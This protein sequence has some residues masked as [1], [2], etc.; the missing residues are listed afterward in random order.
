MS[1]K[2]LKFRRLNDAQLSEIDRLSDRF[3]ELQRDGQ[4]PA[5]S[6]FI[7][8]APPECRESL[9][10]EVLA[11]EI[12]AR[13]RTG[14][15]VSADELHKRFPEYREGIRSVLR[16]MDVDKHTAGSASSG[17]AS[18]GSASSG[19]VNLLQTPDIPASIGDFRIIRELGRGGMGVVYEAEQVSLDRRVA[20]KVLARNVLTDGRD[21]Q[22]FDREAR[23]AGGLH[24]SNIVPVFGVGS[25]QGIDYLVMQLISGRSL[26]TVIRD[27]K[28]LRTDSPS[29]GS[30]FIVAR[31]EVLRGPGSVQS[32]NAAANETTQLA[33][34]DTSPVSRTQSGA[35]FVNPSNILE[36]WRDVA[37]LMRQAANA[38]Q[39]AHEQ[40]VQHRDIKPANLLV[41][42]HGRIWLTD[43]GLAKAEGAQDLTQTGTLL[44]TV[45]YMPPEAFQ[46]KADHTADIYALGL[47]L[48]ELAALRP[49]FETDDNKQAI[50]RVMHTT[51]PA[52]KNI[53]AEIPQDLQTIIHKAIE[54]ESRNRYQT[55]ADFAEDLR[56]F[57]YDEPILARRVSVVEH[58]SRWARQHK[59]VAVLASTLAAV[60]LGAVT[61]LSIYTNRVS[62]L[63]SELNTKAT[64]LTQ[65][66]DS[67]N[68]R[69][70]E[71]ATLA[72]K[73]QSAVVGLKIASAYG[74]VKDGNISRALVT[75]Q[76]AWDSDTFGS[77]GDRAHQMRI[78]AL[79]NTYPELDGLVMST[80]RKSRP[81]YQPWNDLLMLSGDGVAEIWKPS[82]SELIRTIKYESQASAEMCSAGKLLVTRHGNDCRVWDISTGKVIHTLEHDA[83]VRQ[84][85]FSPDAS[86]IATAC[87]DQTIRFWHAIDGRLSET[88]ID[89]ENTKTAFLNFVDNDRIIGSSG[90]DQVRMWSTKTGKAITPALIHRPSYAFPPSFTFADERIATVDGY[91]WFLWS[92]NDGSPLG[93]YETSK[94]IESVHFCEHGGDVLVNAAA[95][96]VTWHYDF[97]EGM[98]AAPIVTTL[99]NPRQSNKVAISSDGDLAAARSTGGTAFV[100]NLRTGE[101]MAE[102][103]N[104]RWLEF[105]DYRRL[106]VTGG[107]STRIFSFRHRHKPKFAERVDEK[108]SVGLRWQSGAN[109]AISG[110]P[111]QPTF[112]FANGKGQ[113]LD[114]DGAQLRE[115]K[116]NSAPTA[117]FSA[118]FGPDRNRLFT[119]N[120]DLYS[121]WDATTGEQ[122][123]QSLQVPDK[124]AMHTSADGILVALRF[125]SE[126]AAIWNMEFGRFLVDGRTTDT[127]SGPS[128]SQASLALLSGVSSF[129]MAPNGKYVVIS[130]HGSETYHVVDVDTLAERFQVD[131][132][133]GVLATIQFT[134]DSSRFITAN[135]DTTVR[136]WDAMSGKQI[137]PHLPHPTFARAATISDDGSFAAS[138]DSYGVIR[139]WDV[140]SG[141]Q[142]GPS[143]DG[144]EFDDNL[145]SFSEDLN[146]L[147]A[148]PATGSVLQHRLPR[149][150]MDRESSRLLVELVT[151]LRDFGSGRSETLTA[152]LTQNREQYMVA[153]RQWRRTI[154]LAQDSLENI[155]T[156]NI[157]TRLANEIDRHAFYGNWT[158]DG[159]T[160]TSDELRFSRIELPVEPVGSY[161]I[162]MDFTRR[163]G[164]DHI[165]IQL[166]FANG[167][168]LFVI[169][170]F[171][172]KG[173]V[174]LEGIDGRVINR[175]G[176]ELGIQAPVDQQRSLT[177]SVRQTGPHVN[178]TAQLDGTEIY[179]W[180]GASRRLILHNTLDVPH[181]RRPAIQT[182]KSQFQIQGLRI[183]RL[184]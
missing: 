183:D 24:H 122:I 78:G 125:N 5:I 168:T 83:R 58:L 96:S 51:P 97:P 158:C 50:Q 135:S 85:R 126:Q 167:R 28:R 19:S 73:A 13:Q 138:R 108:D 47:S 169:D 95:T 88:S 150:A 87:A 137:G 56:R 107:S 21:R 153:W 146:R 74:H 163:T 80:G 178:I 25:E 110:L 2:N 38:L 4:S 10:E 11:L 133:R 119:I 92:L 17:S 33:V 181:V 118:R 179:N 63:N 72:R 142:L 175:S 154:D 46:G 64:L 42:L 27:L 132:H 124:A 129:V 59:L 53:A 117:K 131:A 77:R 57:C 144:S 32:E 100:W 20:L 123:G 94:R 35:L 98:A 103:E 49:A 39:Y 67:A 55:A 16:A 36:Y 71:N 105:V 14:K 113:L 171:P 173:L 79:L 162:S 23:A 26:D 182:H 84:A 127:P 1:L 116:L 155:P 82:V 66:N 70:N 140:Y 34:T 143:F 164:T 40:G 101:I 48:Y 170:S 139:T 75:M 3:E 145:L 52:L 93:N 41:D 8:Q 180:S 102:L 65:A 114:T 61:I 90:N 120:H 54:R 184:P 165:G 109:W 111:G 43:F 60:L 15:S 37:E 159:E 99:T 86:I 148:T 112:Q 30:T 62:G 91:K 68:S 152:E 106:M 104:V 81:Q 151:S 115:F 134:A 45:R 157:L 156:D 44:G 161:Q 6:Q 76:S 172:P 29:D 166:P 149:L 176:R 18:S 177:V 22:R 31:R 136:V 69:A 7:E 147:V 128:E 130:R 160:L 89:H 121:I 174:T 12:D 141:E 9:F